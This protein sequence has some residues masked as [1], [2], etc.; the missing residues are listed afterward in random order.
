[1]HLG[2][3]MSQCSCASITAVNSVLSMLM[4]GLITSSCS[5][6][7]HCVLPFGQCQDF[8]I[9]SLFSVKN[10]SDSIALC[11]SN[12]LSECLWTGLKHDLS[13]SCVI[14][15]LAEALAQLPNLL[16]P[17]FRLLVTTYCYPCSSTMYSI[18]LLN[19]V[20]T[21]ARTLALSWL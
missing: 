3:H 18:Y 14:S 2:C 20:M 19:V 1:M 21:V 16:M 13:C 7:V 6:Y 4:V 8:I 17:A 11:F 10:R 15:L 5:I 9:L 12:L